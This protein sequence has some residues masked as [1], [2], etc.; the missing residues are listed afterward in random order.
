MCSWWNGWKGVR[1]ETRQ[2]NKTH[3]GVLLCGAVREVEWR[4]RGTKQ[5][6]GQVHVNIWMSRNKTNKQTKTGKSGEKMS[7]RIQPVLKLSCTHCVHRVP[8]PCSLKTPSPWFWWPLLWTYPG[9]HLSDVWAYEVQLEPTGG[10]GTGQDH[11][12]LG[13][14]RAKRW[15]VEE[16][17]WWGVRR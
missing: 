16:G 2:G 8:G 15:R 9:L 1:K 14:T 11:Q 4:L 6:V 17:K 12:P 13:R 5:L 10:P 7:Q 3:L